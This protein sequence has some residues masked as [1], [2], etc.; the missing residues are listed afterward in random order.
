MRNFYKESYQK[1]K[2]ITEEE[3]QKYV[4]ALIAD[5]SEKD[6]DLSDEFLRNWSLIDDNTY[7]FDYIEKVLENLKNVNREEFIKFYEK[8]FI[9][10]VAIL[11]SEIVCEAH[12]EQ[13]EKD[14]KEAKILEGENI[15]KRIIC[16]TMD[17]FRACNCLGVK[18]DNPVFKSYN[19]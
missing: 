7:E 18:C 10:E 9:N 8:Y 2:E 14:L 19:N 6:D 17:D 12:Y 1:I 13:N 16:E 15:K 11:D 3:F 5:L 4:N